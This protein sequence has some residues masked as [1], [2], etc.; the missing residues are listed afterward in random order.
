[1]KTLED[2]TPEIRAKIPLYKDRARNDLYSGEEYKN[3]KREDCAK[4]VEYVYNL[5]K[6]DLKPVVIIADS[7]SQYKLFW[8]LI[9]NDR[10]NDDT[11]KVIDQI[12]DLKNG[13]KIDF[14]TSLIKGMNPQLVKEFASELG[15]ELDPGQ[16]V[17]VSEKLFEQCKQHYLFLMSEYSRVYLTWYAFINRE[18]NLPLKKNQDHLDWLYDNVNKASIAKGFFCEKVVLILRMP[19][20]IIRNK[21]GFHSAFEPAIQY[22][23]EGM[24]YLNGRKMENWVFEDYEKG[25][26]TFEKFNKEQNEDIRAGI[27]TLIKER[28]GNEGLIKFLGAQVVDEQ[29]VVHEGGYTETLKLYKTKQKFPELQ[30]SKGEYNQQA[31]WIYM[32]CPSTGQSYLI[33]TCPLFKDAVEC[34]KWHRP[35]GVPAS[36]PYLWQ[37]AN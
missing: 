34:A 18:F 15:M 13:K 25:T 24:Y 28:E 2:L 33:D 14:D 22:P 12:L 10:I 11:Y 35:K 9:F 16:E 3:W 29:T 1:M 5:A 8:N 37:S 31:A 21:I 17:P 27:I 26:L 23:N 7:P 36:V 6:R 4:Y 30:N 19:S 20:K 32:V